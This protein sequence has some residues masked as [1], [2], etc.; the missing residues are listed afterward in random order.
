MGNQGPHEW[1]LINWALGNR[2]SLPETMVAAGNRFGWD[3]AGNT[4]N[5]M[6]CYGTHGGIPFS[7]EVMDLKEAG[8]APRRVGVGVLIETEGGM[9][10]GGRG[11]GTFEHRDGRREKFARDESQKGGDG[12]VAHMG[13]FAEAIL[14]GDRSLLRSE[15]AVAANSSAMAHMANIAFRLGE[16]SSPDAVSAAFAATPRTEEMIARLIAAPEKFAAL[17]SNVTLDQPWILGQT[18][19]YDNS[20]GQFTGENADAANRLMTRQYRAGFELPAV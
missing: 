1:D 10:A 16:S 6:A 20:A 5:V 7:F 8:E 14:A 18:H 12:L 19:G 4:P 11:G 17:N 3:D 9:F 15:A 2:P 13:N